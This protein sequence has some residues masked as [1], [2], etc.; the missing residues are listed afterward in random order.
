LNT[1][2]LYPNSEKRS[3]PWD[4]KMFEEFGFETITAVQASLY[5][6]LGLGILFGVFSE[7]VKFCFRRAL[8]GSDRAQAAGVWAMALLVAVM[9][10]HYFVTTDII[11][12]DDHRFMGNF[13]IV[14]IVLGGLAFGAGM[15]LTRGCVGRLTV[16]GATGNLRAMTALLIFA[17]VAHATLKGVLSPLRTATGDIGPTID[18]LSLS[19]VFGSTLPLVIIAGITSGIIWRSGSSIVSLFSG[20]TIGALVVAGWVGTGFLLYDDFDPI[21]FESIAFTSPWTD[22]IFW[23]LASTSVSA[24]F[25]VGL[26]GGV[27][28]GAFLSAAVS[29]RLSWQSF[30]GPA[31]FGRFAAGASLMGFGGVLAGGCTIG[32]GLSGIPSLSIVP[33][34]A[35]LSIA[36]GAVITHRLVDVIPST[37]E[38]A[39]QGTTQHQQPA[40]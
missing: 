15:V 31:H 12:F 13:P 14:Q 32:A 39:A 36:V 27:I 30:D 7:Q 34:T 22:S 21:G 38:S 10:T 29:G 33:I 24:K 4:S 18:A 1:G 35:L 20:A 9:G 40:E 8:I 26:I 19:D 25:G 5:F 37:F 3:N 2:A 6:A 11:A 17:V 23:T 16:L 28:A